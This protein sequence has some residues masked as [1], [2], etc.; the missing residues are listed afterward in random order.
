M[1]T[2]TAW[3]RA[4]GLQLH[5]RAVC[6]GSAHLGPPCE[7]RAVQTLV[8]SERMEN[9]GHGLAVEET[10]QDIWAQWPGLLELLEH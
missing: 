8:P 5:V 9:L 6:A 10:L 3:P 1:L 4:N 2:I 7:T